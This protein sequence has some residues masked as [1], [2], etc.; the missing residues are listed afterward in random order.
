M[1]IE[2]VVCMTLKPFYDGIKMYKF[3]K[4]EKYQLKSDRHEGVV[5][6]ALNELQ[7]YSPDLNI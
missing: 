2:I 3:Q 6:R 4:R 7:K 1:E 5:V